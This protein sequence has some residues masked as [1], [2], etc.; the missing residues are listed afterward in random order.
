MSGQGSAAMSWMARGASAATL[1]LMAGGAP[2]AAAPVPTPVTDITDPRSVASAANPRA[3]P[4]PIGDLG[5][6]RNAMGAVW[7]PDGRSVVVSTNLAGRYNLWRV[8]LGGNF[9]VQLALSENRQI[10]ADVTRDGKVL[11]IE[12]AGGNEMWDLYAV[13]LAGGAVVNLTKSPDFAEIRP[14]LSPDGHLVGLTRRAKT[15]STM[16]LAVLDRRTGAVRQLTR[17]SDPQR[18]WSASGWSPDGKVLF[19]TRTNAPDTEAAVY[20]VDLAT[21]QATALTDTAPGVHI[22]ATDATPDGRTLAVTSKS[23]DQTRAGLLDVATGKI[24]WLK[25]TPWEQLSSTFSPNGRQ[26]LVQTNADGRS[27]LSLVDVATLAERPLRLPPGVVEPGNPVAPWS[28]NGKLIVSQDSGNSPFDYHAVDPASGKA[29]RVTRLAVA[30]LDPANLPRTQIVAYRSSDGTPISAVLTLPF[31][32]K[33]DGS[34]PA[35]ILPHGGPAAQSR[36]S[37]GQIGTALASRGY[38]VLQPN[39]RG[40]T[41]YGRAFHAANKKDAGGGDLEDVVAGAKFLVDTGYADPKRIGIGGGS[42]GGFLTLM[43]LAK[44]PDVFAA[45]VDMY[46]VIDW[47]TMWENAAGGLREYLRSLVGDPVED[48]ALYVKQSPITY[49]KNIRAPL[50]VL[51]GENDVRVPKGQSDDVV[52]T[53]KAQGNIVEAH[54]YAGEGHGFAK[55]ENQQDARRRFIEWFEKHL[56]GAPA[57][58]R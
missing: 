20:R 2:V 36:D 58:A 34:N 21:G 11:F 5:G 12:D 38:L 7:A 22:A 23:G 57:A 56:T 4:V 10:P 50:L 49:I 44:R 35:V 39:F 3:A 43:A 40:S 17:E 14:R 15:S 8:D 27:H 54:Y 41:G 52:R 13:P 30:S 51:Q 28:R 19:A 33:R 16:E 25:A 1:I 53:L 48:K 31:N 18:R 55:V 37:F 24:R 46:G 9:P 6:V 45:G 29:E 42:Y 26:L 47:N 32:L